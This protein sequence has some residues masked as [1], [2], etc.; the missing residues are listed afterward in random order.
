MEIWRAGALRAGWPLRTEARH[1]E[2]SRRLGGWSFSSELA[3]QPPALD[4]K[5][6]SYRA[7][8]QRIQ[9]GLE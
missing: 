5:A 1:V 7:D 8:L 4:A 6:A 9:R 2:R 3:Q